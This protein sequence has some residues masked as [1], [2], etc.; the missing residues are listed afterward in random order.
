MRILLAITGALA[1]FTLACAEGTF[2]PLAGIL[3]EPLDSTFVFTYGD[4]NADSRH[5]IEPR[6]PEER[7]GALL[8]QAEVIP[9]ET[10]VPFESPGLWIVVNVRNPT[11]DSAE[12]RLQGCTVW[13]EA[14]ASPAR[15]EDP[16]W[17]P[18]GEC[19]QQP[20]TSIVPP[21]ATIQFPFLAH[22]VMLANALPDGRYYFTARFRRFNDTLALVAGSGDVR[23]RVPG[24]AY[25]VQARLE[26]R[27]AVRAEVSMENR[28]DER[29]QVTFGHCALGLT[30]YRDKDR[31]QLLRRWRAQD[32][33]LSY[34]AG[35][36][37]AP[38]DS[39]QPDEW[40]HTFHVSKLAE[41][42]ITPGRYHLSVSLRHNWRT[43]EFPVGSLFIR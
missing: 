37:L 33:C 5:P 16:L 34:L 43:Y 30:V 18:A 29:V 7:I 22:D 20:L 25:H 2:G 23:L 31:T 12:L 9:T 15:A 27:H 24:L 1:L 36:D 40:V 41:S 42:G 8:Y 28:N 4:F 35:V 21:D 6:L 39:R 38:G 10:D 13:P 11:P 14:Y 26:G 17:V 32:F 19:M 3:L